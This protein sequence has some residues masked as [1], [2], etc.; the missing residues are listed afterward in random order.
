MWA[1]LQEL[2][3]RDKTTVFFTTHYMEEAERVAQRIAIID[4]GKIVASGT[5]AELKAQTGTDTLEGA[6]LKLTGTTIR[7]ERADAADQMRQMGRM[8]AGRR[9]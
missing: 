8:W 4:H 3:K 9:R 2:N 5:S 7:D 6:F 1:Y